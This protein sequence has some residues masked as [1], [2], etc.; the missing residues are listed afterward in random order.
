MFCV[1]FYFA[2]L[3]YGVLNTRLFSVS[4]CRLTLQG[5]NWVRV[6]VQVSVITNMLRRFK[7]IE[8]RPYKGYCSGCRNWGEAATVPVSKYCW[9]FL[10]TS[11]NTY[12]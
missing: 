2:R 3:F 1:S 10:S 11:S 6:C 5:G 9:L 7:L 4:S 8:S 12:L